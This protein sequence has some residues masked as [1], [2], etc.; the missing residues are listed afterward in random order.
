M[1]KAARGRIIPGLRYEDAAAAIDWLCNAFGFERHLVVEDDSG[2]IAHAQLVLGPC[3]IMLG[4]HADDEYG[5]HMTT[6]AQAGGNTQAAYV[7]VDNVDAHYARA[8]AAGADIFM[9]IE[10][11][12]YGGRG[13]G[14]KDLEGHI[15]NSGSDV[16]WP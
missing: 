12:D 1:S 8:K 16:P 15:W 2:G 6:P 5:R 9:D 3:M 4:G 11:K 10:D 14:C 7:V 13:Y